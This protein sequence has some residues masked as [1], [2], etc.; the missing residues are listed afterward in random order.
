MS[1]RVIAVAV[2]LVLLSAS[3]AFAPPGVF[4]ATISLGD[5]A[6]SGDAGKSLPG[7]NTENMSRLAHLR[8]VFYSG[9]ISATDLTGY[10]D[11]PRSCELPACLMATEEEIV[12]TAYRALKTLQSVDEAPADGEAWDRA[13]DVWNTSIAGVA[14]IA[15]L[16][17]S[18]IAYIVGRRQGEGSSSGTKR[19]TTTR[20]AKGTTSATRT[21]ARTA[22][23][24]AA[25]ADPAG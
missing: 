25:K 4:S 2:G 21:R 13:I 14:A 8:I 6:N 23:K 7:M 5:K 10:A 3:A 11:D 15:G 19:K 18:A 24:N 22:A 12:S 1:F 20:T 9:A 16:S 17:G